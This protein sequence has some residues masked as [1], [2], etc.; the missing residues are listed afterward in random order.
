M[1]LLLP[2]RIK[3]T[4]QMIVKHVKVI[5]TIHKIT[6]VE[7]PITRAVDS[8]TGSNHIGRCKILEIWFNAKPKT[9]GVT[10]ATY[11]LGQKLEMHR[12]REEKK[13]PDIKMIYRYAKKNRSASP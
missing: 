2:E 5:V 11:L 8:F 10:F 7:T 12:P 13:A 1:I 6:G 9:K 4:S 3:T